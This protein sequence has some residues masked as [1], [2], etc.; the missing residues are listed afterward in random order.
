[1]ICVL[2]PL[3]AVRGRVGGEVRPALARGVVIVCGSR[4]FKGFSLAA[5]GGWVVAA[6]VLE[7]G[8]RWRG[9]PFV[10]FGLMGTWSPVLEF[11]GIAVATVAWAPLVLE[12]GDGTGR[13]KTL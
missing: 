10:V 3:A 4:C 2:V 1:M 5:E 7:S 11:A 13:R 6:C 12:K 9:T 8:E